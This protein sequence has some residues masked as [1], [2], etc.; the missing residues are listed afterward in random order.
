MT[1]NHIVFHFIPLRAPHFGGHWERAI[2]SAKNHMRRVIGDQILTIEE[3]NTLCCCIEAMLNITP[4][5]S[6]PS[7]MNVLT[8]G[9]FLTGGPLVTLPDLDRT[10]IT[11]NRLNRWQLVQSFS[12]HIWKHWHNEYLHTLQ[13]RSKWIKPHKNL[14]KGD[15]VLIQEDNTPS[16]QWRMGRVSKAISGK[17]NI[18]RVVEVITAKGCITR[19]VTKLAVLPVALQV[20]AT[21]TVIHLNQVV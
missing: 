15:L 13:H 19:P 18:V 2:Q 16:L 12:Q 3:F 21:K 6:D 20:K 17:D 14:E 4:L 10:E 11:L 7:E 1:N 9:H 5:Y 8:P